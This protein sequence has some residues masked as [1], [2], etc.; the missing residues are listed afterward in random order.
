MVHKK[1]KV[2]TFILV[3]NLFISLINILDVIKSMRVLFLC[4]DSEVL[5]C[6]CSSLADFH[7]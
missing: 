3:Q 4:S 7:N 5:Q 1:H 2:P 6:S